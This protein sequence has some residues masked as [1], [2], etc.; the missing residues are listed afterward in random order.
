MSRRYIF[1]DECGNFDFSVK[2]GASAFFIIVTPC[3]GD[4][5]VGDALLNLRRELAW[6]GIGLDRE[7]HATTDQ[8]VVRDRVFAW[9]G[10]SI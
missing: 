10:G 6:E 2:S 8:Q 1:A 7:F 5:S 3:I 4:C 9:R